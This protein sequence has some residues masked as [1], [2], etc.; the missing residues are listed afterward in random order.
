MT[1]FRTKLAVILLTT[2]LN[3]LKACPLTKNSD[4][5]IGSPSDVMH[6]TSNKKRKN[7]ILTMMK[8]NKTLCSRGSQQN[9]RPQTCQRVATITT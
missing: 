7:V 8:N 2:D 1:Q 4:D 3:K 6:I 9:D 5:E